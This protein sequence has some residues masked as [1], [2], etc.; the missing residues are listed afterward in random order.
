MATLA[1]SLV[2]TTSR[3]LTMRMRPDLSARL[4]RYHGKTFWVVKEPVGLNYFRFHEE[5][6]AIL[7]MLDG[8]SS[9]DDIKAKFED[10]YTP[11]KITYQDLQQ[12][13]GMLHRSG[14]VIS[15]AP[16]QGRQL[17]R[18]RDEKKKREW[19]GRLTNIFAPFSRSA[20]EASIPSGSS[21]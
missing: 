17:K 3:K 21:T 4:H 20:S 15:D 8:H 1:E 13:I 11:Q 7:C 19:M 5:E 18:R 2:S 12:F 9:L 10:E 16:G 14:L 6:Y